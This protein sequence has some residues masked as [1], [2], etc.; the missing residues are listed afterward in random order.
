MPHLSL[1]Q[2]AIFFRELAALLNSGLSLHHSL[3]MAGKGMGKPF[4]QHLQAMGQA[5]AA[6]EALAPVMGRYP[7]Y[8]DGWTVSL[9]R[10][11]EYSG[12][13]GEV[14]RRL[15][16]LTEEQQRRQRLYQ[17]LQMNVLTT[18]VS[19]LL[20]TAVLGRGVSWLTHPW[21]W[22]LIVAL[23]VLL[24]LSQRWL[25]S[26][27]FKQGWHPSLSHLPLIGP[28]LEIRSLLLLSDLALPLSCG[29][30]LLTAVELLRDRV[31]DRRLASHLGRAARQIRQG[32]SLGESLQGQVAPIALQMIRTGE[33][34]G[35]LEG[36][37]TKLGEYYEGEME[38]LLRQ[39]QVFLRLISLLA[40]AG[41]VLM[42]GLQMI[43]TFPKALP[44]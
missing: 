42:L 23:V 6:G 31:T 19:L 17:S 26:K 28:L 22:L 27:V 15:A 41:L 30:P 21:F 11:A 10:L 36:M 29:V 4:Q 12:L 5:I 37:L 25:G 18:L 38:R 14:C 1:K 43:A 34:T 8:F 3:G 40:F 13:L 20:I 35:N 33:E 2:R 9:I 16:D 24:G 32:R 44:D 39:A 7:Q